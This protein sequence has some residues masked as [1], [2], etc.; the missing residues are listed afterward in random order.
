MKTQSLLT[1]QECCSKCKRPI[2]IGFYVGSDLLCKEC[3]NEDQ[4]ITWETYLNK[5]GLEK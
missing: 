4:K 3:F 2:M 5:L 1:K